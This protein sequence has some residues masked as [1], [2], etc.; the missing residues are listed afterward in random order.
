MRPNIVLHDAQTNETL[1]REMTEQEYADLLATGWTEEGPS[2]AF[3][4]N[5]DVQHAP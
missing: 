3:G 2:N 1:C 4:N 5:T